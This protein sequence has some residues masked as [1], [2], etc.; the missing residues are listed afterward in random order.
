MM[1]RI[2]LGKGYLTL[3]LQRQWEASTEELQPIARLADALSRPP[4]YE[5]RPSY[6]AFGPRLARQIVRRLGGTVEVQTEPGEEP[7]DL[8]F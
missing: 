1:V 5:H 4:Y 8:V 6:G 2:K 7:E 3:T